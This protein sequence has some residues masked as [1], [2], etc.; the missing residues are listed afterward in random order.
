MAFNTWLD[1]FISEKELDLD[2][3]F[4]IEG[5]DWDMNWIPLQCVID[6]I[7]NAPAIEQ[8]AIRKT[9]VKID[10]VDGDVMHFFEHL[11]GALAI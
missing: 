8:D 3:T 6:E 4:E 1:T 9:I 11:A 2:Y 10:F 7:K 5:D